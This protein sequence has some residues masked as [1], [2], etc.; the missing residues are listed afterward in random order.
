MK[1]SIQ[2][3][4]DRYAQSKTGSD[5][6]QATNAYSKYLFGMKEAQ[7]GLRLLSYMFKDE[8]FSTRDL[9]RIEKM[10]VRLRDDKQLEEDVEALISTYMQRDGW[11]RSASQSK[12]AARSKERQELLDAYTQYLKSLDKAQAGARWMALLL[13][14]ENLSGKIP[15]DIEKDLIR[16]HGDKGMENEFNKLS[17]ILMEKE[18]TRRRASVYVDGESYMSV[19]GLQSLKDHAEDLLG[20]VGNDTPL[21]DWVEAKITRAA[22]AI[23]DVYEYMNHGRGQNL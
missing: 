8:K 23:N 7:T 3:V 16:L 18:R 17:M 21:P 13:E 15:R 6:R 9:K 10:I 20:Q 12:T 22:Q 2:R 4:M 11:S 19:Q 5:R 14:D 1:P